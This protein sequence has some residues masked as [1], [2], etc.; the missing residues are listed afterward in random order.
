MF[1]KV[2]CITALCFAFAGCAASQAK[3]VATDECLGQCRLTYM[4][5]MENQTCVNIDGQVIPC[6]RKCGDEQVQC[7]QG[8]AGQR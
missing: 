3:G 4:T 8:C 7:E 1:H 5:C 2:L 6:E